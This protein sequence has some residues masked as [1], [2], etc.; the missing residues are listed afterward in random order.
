MARSLTSL[1]AA[2][3]VLAAP[4]FSQAAERK[5][6]AEEL[7]DIAR[8]EMLWCENYVAETNDCDVIT[9]VR[10]VPDGRLAETSTLLLQED[11]RLQVFIGDHDRIDGDR[12]CS[13]I[14]SARTAFAFTVEGQPAPTA[15]AIGLRLLFMAQ[16]AELDGKTLCQTFFRDDATGVVREEI[17]VDGERRTDLESTYVLREG[18]ERLNLRPQAPPDDASA[19]IQI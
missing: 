13:T 14:E 6:T 17:T 11:P 18:S 1:I 15:T 9:L 8:R 12:L 10:L 16:L 19:R 4:A 2:V 7:R 5:M 3:S